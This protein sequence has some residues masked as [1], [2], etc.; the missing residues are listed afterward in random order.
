[1]TPDHRTRRRLILPEVV[2]TLAMDCGPAV[3]ACLLQGFGIPAEYGRLREACQTDV[4][5]TSIGTIDWRSR[6]AW[7]AREWP[8]GQCCRGAG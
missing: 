4:D 2:Q 5:G 8:C 1:M 6:R 7:T 3:L